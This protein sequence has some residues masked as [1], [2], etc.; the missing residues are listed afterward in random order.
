MN[1]RENRQKPT[2]K[3]R[4]TVLTVTEPSELMKFLIAQLP[5]KSRNTIKSLLSHRQIMVENKSISQFN[6]PLTAGQQVIVNWNKVAEEVKYHELNIV[7]EDDDLIVIEKQT[8]LL[9]SY[10]ILSS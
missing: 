5:D 6:H 9:S 4:K 8:G 7:Y 1:M 2:E 3:D 10:T